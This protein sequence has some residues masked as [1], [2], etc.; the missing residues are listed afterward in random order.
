MSANTFKLG[1]A[2]SRLRRTTVHLQLVLTLLLYY[3]AFV[4]TLAR[5]TQRPAAPSRRRR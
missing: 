2:S 5:E 3:S 4:V 1:F